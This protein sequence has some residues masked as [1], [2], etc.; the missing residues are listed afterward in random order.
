[1]ISTEPCDQFALTS[2]QSFCRFS[3]GALN[4]STLK[5]WKHYINSICQGTGTCV[6]EIWKLAAHDNHF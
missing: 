2:A 6:S 5:Q 1:M 4:K 3:P